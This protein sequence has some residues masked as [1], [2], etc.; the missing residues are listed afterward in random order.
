MFEPRGTSGATIDK[1]GLGILRQPEGTRNFEIGYGDGEKS[2]YTLDRSG[3][4][5]GEDEKESSKTID[6]RQGKAT[7]GRSDRAEVRERRER[8]ERAAGELSYADILSR[9]A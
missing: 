8:D 7:E 2:R 5:G 4:E 9:T 3:G 6:T 1:P